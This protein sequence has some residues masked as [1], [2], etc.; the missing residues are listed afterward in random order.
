[1]DGAMVKDYDHCKFKETP[2][3]NKFKKRPFFG[4]AMSGRDSRPPANGSGGLG[5]LVDES[6]RNGREGP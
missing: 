3:F 2:C 4:V 1:M 5:S 6:Y